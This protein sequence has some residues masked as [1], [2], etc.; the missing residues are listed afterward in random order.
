MIGGRRT[1]FNMR[2]HM[3]LHAL[4]E[5]LLMSFL[6][7]KPSNQFFKLPLQ[8]SMA[9]VKVG[10]T[11]ALNKWDLISQHVTT[12]SASFLI[13]PIKAFILVILCLLLD[14]SKKPCE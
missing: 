5:N 11:K 6:T 3:H 7:R 1:H 9:C 4:F 8:N 10:S 12:T 14:G 13:V 2:Q